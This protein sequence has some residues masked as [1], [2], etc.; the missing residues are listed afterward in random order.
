MRQ[1]ISN[2]MENLNN[3]VYHLDL[4]DIYKTLQPMNG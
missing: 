3:T 1:K 2:G 4:I